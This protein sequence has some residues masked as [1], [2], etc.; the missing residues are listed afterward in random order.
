MFAKIITDSNTGFKMDEAIIRNNF[1]IGKNLHFTLLQTSNFNVKE[2]RLLSK[3]MNNHTTLNNLNK[4]V[5]F[6]N[7]INDKE[8]S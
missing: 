7:S 8:D 1:E 4:T 3:E 6:G 5:K 2:L